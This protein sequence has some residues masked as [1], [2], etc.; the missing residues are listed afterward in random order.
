MCCSWGSNLDLA[1]CTLFLL[2]GVI[3]PCTEISH[4]TVFQICISRQDLSPELQKHLTSWLFDSPID[5]PST[6]CQRIPYPICIALE[7]LIWAK[8]DSIHPTCLLSFTVYQIIPKLCGLKQQPFLSAQL[9]RWGMWAEISQ[10]VLPLNPAGF[11]MPSVT[12]QLMASFNSRW[13][14]VGWGD[15]SRAN[16][17]MYPWSHQLTQAHLPS[18]DHR[19]TKKSKRERK[20]QGLWRPGFELLQHHCCPFYWSEQITRPTQIQGV[21]K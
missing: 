14:A 3:C 13:L 7:F 10:A 17:A 4:M 19:I 15:T 8:G 1:S 2:S 11:V 18:S 5:S 20:V 16:W 12:G 21:E 9:H 6:L